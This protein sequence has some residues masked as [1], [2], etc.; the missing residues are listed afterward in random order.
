MPRVPVGA[1]DQITIVASQYNQQFT[2]GLVQAA[3]NELGNLASQSRVD[4]IR[5]PG[6]YEIPLA[7]KLILENEKPQAIICLGL[8]LEGETAH[9]ELIASSVTDQLL[10]LSLNNNIPIIHEVLLVENQE[11]AIA[12]CLG[13]K[14]NRG[15]DAARAAAEMI[16]VCKELTKTSRNR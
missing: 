14:I 9:A 16:G 2:D 13:D 5:V 6:A 10:S 4:L 11:Q 3:I 12:R 8:I 7:T 15:T 1:R